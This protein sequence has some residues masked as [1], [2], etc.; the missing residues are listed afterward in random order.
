M[1]R[2]IDVTKRFGKRLV[3]DNVSLEI[4]RGETLVIIG[5]SGIG[6]TVTLRHIGG[7]LD[8]DEGEVWVDSDRM[9]FADDKRKERLRSKMGFLFQSGALL[10]WLSVKDNVAL[11]LIE[12]KLCK[13]NQVES[14][15]EETLD[16]LQLLDAKDK[17][18]SEISGGMKKRAGLARALVSKPEIILY[19]EPTSGLDPVMSSL[20]NRIIRKL[21]KEY[22]VTSV[23]VT[24]DMK[25]AY[26]IG[27]RIA[28]L[29]NAKIIQCA[30]PDEIRQTNNPIVRQFIE[31]LLEGPINAEKQ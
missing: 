1:I 30:T 22:S 29:F 8:P 16:S 25:S 18:I 21:Q 4:K 10:N 7:L 12:R 5:Q 27:D 13:P 6:K 17:M 20:I 3:L 31:G 11:P 26:E 19:D 14:L 24:H 23:V 15:V 28:M 2:L 9:D